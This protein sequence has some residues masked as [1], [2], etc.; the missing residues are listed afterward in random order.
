MECVLRAPAVCGWIGEWTDDLQLLDDRAGP[1]VVDDERQ[2]VF[3]FRTNVD[4][5]DVEPVDLGDELRQGVQLRL[6]LAPIVLRRPIVGELLHRRE[7][8]ALGLIGDG[9]LFGPARGLYA[10]AKGIELGLR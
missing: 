4:E 10:P 1:S 3:V 9:L 5:V 7:L 6:A 2:R 8:H